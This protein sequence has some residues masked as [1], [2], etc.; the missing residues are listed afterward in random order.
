MM[1]GTEQMTPGPSLVALTDD[2]HP[3]L[4]ELRRRGPVQWVD[5]L[6]GWLVTA[7]AEAAAVMRDAATFTVDDP[8]FSTSRVVGPSMLSTDGIEHGRH[9][10]PFLAPFTPRASRAYFAEFVK[11]EAARLVSTFAGSGTAELRTALAAPLATA[12][13]QLALGLQDIPV[14]ELL[15]WYGAIVAAVAEITAGSDPPAYGRDAYRSL[16]VAVEA[17]IAAGGRD[18]FLGQVLASADALSTTEM[19]SN[20]AVLMFGGIETTEGMIANL[21]LHVL[22]SEHALADL[23]AD[24]TLI[25]AAIEESLRLEPAAAVV[26]RYATRDIEL[27]GAKIRRGDLVVVSLAG[28]NRDPEIFDEPDV[29]DLHRVNARRHLAFAQGPHTCIGLHLARLEARCAVQEV[30]ALDGIALD[31]I[32]SSAPTGLVFRKPAA[33]AATWSTTRRRPSSS[34]ASSASGRD[35]AREAR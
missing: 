33:V 8:R 2:P 13:M 25:D 10:Q 23:R 7:H 27:A 31:K 17:T 3:L 5:P 24:S 14:A 19:I 32:R 15:G 22:G 9:R 6:G 21:L 26:D 34:V 4:A 18:T 11:T 20:A 29:F 16:S 35:P 30:L 1:P 28:A 12:S